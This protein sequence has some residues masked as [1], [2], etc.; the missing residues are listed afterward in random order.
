MIQWGLE[1][2]MPGALSEDLRERVVAA[3]EAGEGTQE[4]VAKRFGVGVASL[5]RWVRLK[6][7]TG[8]LSPRPRPGRAPLLTAEDRE[9]FARICAE[10]VDATQQELADALAAAGGP[11]VSPFTI[12]RELKRLGWTRKKN[13]PSGRG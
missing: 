12:A 4:E 13:A 5:V 7:D 1:V 2:E 3:W 11:T 8:S 9:V 6:R 10:Q